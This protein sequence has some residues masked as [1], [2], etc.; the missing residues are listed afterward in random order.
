[1]SGITLAQAQAQLD[2]HLSASAKILKGQRVDLEGVSLT[3]ADLRA[4]REGIEYWRKM[5]ETLSASASGR[6]RIL[7]SVVRD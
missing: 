1:M 6:R 2:A 7:A 5:V 4:V 3:R